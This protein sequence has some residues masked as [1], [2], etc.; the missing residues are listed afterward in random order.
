[1]PN[2]FPKKPTVWVAQT[3]DDFERVEAQ[4]DE[5]KHA[6]D[7]AIKQISEMSD[8]IGKVEAGR[9]KLREALLHA[10]GWC[11][12]CNGEGVTDAGGDCRTCCAVRAI[13]ENVDRALLAE[14]DTTREGEE[15]GG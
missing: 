8:E 13:E 11:P 14:T 10:M 1:M 4:R 7:E 2:P 15:A 6:L 9:E 12:G 3:H 5:A